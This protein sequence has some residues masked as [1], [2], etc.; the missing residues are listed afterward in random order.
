MSSAWGKRMSSAWGKRMSSAWGK[1][2]EGDSE[3]FYNQ[4]L[5]EL[6]RQAHL[7]NKND[8]P[9]FDNDCK[10]IIFILNDKRFFFSFLFSL[11]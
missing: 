2:A 3:E 5:R 4:L 11:W 1:R 10:N 7:N 8:Y 6:Y 9:R